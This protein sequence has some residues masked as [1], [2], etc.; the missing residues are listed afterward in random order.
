[1][2][3]I[4]AHARDRILLTSMIS[5]SGFEVGAFFYNKGILLF[6]IL[7]SIL[8]VLKG[9]CQVGPRDFAPL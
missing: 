2:V 9:V 4:I 3:K 6:P 1:M 7:T 5:G 8:M